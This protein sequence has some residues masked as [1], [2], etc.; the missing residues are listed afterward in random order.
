MTS[1]TQPARQHA[2]RPPLLGQ[3]LA[4]GLLGGVLLA[5]AWAD[6]DAFLAGIA[7]VQL[8][9]VLGFL[10]VTEAPAAT[11]VFGIGIA[12]AV[13]AD[14]VVVVDDG[15]ARY[16]GG[17]VGLAL[18]LGLLHQLA[19]RERSRVTE[20]L[21]DTLVVVTLVTATAGL[22]AAARTADGTWPTRA[23]LAAAAAAL[24][25][26]R[27]ADRVVHRPALA[28]GS[29][30]AWPG[31]LLALGAGVAAATV[32]AHD[33][34]DK[35]PLLGLAAAAAVAA[36]DLLLDLAAAELTASHEDARRVAALR[37]TSLFVPFALLG[38]V[39]LT[40]VRL[41]DR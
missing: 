40:A 17:V 8:V 41:L 9:S 25:A 33:H 26:G 29:T 21:A 12:A 18:V 27:V 23:A 31:L 3:G 36:A 32:T 6:R 22:A 14:V 16:L 30:R 4:G 28:I 7:V 20:S 19:R 13:A 38:P 10:A 11:G 34:L 37:P 24:L 35:A 2:P 5:L 15:R 39:V 1:A